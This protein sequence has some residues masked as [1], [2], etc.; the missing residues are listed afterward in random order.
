MAL[1]VGQ[2]A[3]ALVSPLG[4]DGGQYDQ[5]SAYIRRKEVA[6]SR[7]DPLCRLWRHLPLEGEII[8]TAAA[9]RSPP[10]VAAPVA[11]PATRGL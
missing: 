6:S 9:S 1:M 4:E 8:R 3:E 2:K 7:T 11:S 10:R 5:V